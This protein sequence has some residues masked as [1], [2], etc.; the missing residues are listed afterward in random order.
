MKITKLFYLTVGFSV[1]AATSCE[2]KDLYDPEFQTKQDAEFIKN[3]FDFNLS[4]TVPINL[5]VGRKALVRVYGT[6]PDKDPAAEP[7]YTAYT[8]NNGEYSGMFV[9]PTSYINKTLYAVATDIHIPATVSTSGVSFV[10][11]AGR[12][13]EDETVKNADWCL[14]WSQYYRDHLVER[15]DNTGM[16]NQTDNIDLLTTGDDTKISV[17]FLYSGASVGSRVYYYYYSKDDVPATPTECQEIFYRF[18]N[19]GDR[20]CLFANEGQNNNG[21]LNGWANEVENGMIG[22]NQELL[23][24][25]P[26]GTAESGTDFPKDVYVG[27]FLFSNWDDVCPP[28]FTNRFFNAQSN[29]TTNAGG[30]RPYVES[31]ASDLVRGKAQAGVFKNAEAEVLFY[32][33]E[34]LPVTYTERTTP[35]DPCDHDFNDIILAVHTD[36]DKI[37]E[38]DIEELD[39]NKVIKLFEGTLLFEDL[40]PEQGDYDMNDVIVE[41]KYSKLVS[42]QD[43][44]KVLAYNYEFR[45]KYDG[46]TY[47]NDFYINV[48]GQVAPIKVYEN[49]AASVGKIFTGVLLENPGVF[50]LTQA[51]V[52]PYIY[53]RNTG[54]E[55]HLSGKSPTAGAKTEGLTAITKLYFSIRDDNEQDQY[56]FAMD[57]PMKNFIP[58]TESV[59]IDTEYP[60]YLKWVVSGGTTNKDWYN[61][62][63][64]SSGN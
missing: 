35:L 6:D 63:Q 40:F 20:F 9:L 48:P 42:N 43:G 28:I 23:Y 52:D 56:P 61:N 58:V 62:Y 46:A 13:S 16:I 10:T 14:K 34:D 51:S 12:A 31:T 57:I 29:I 11:S 36:F 3:A 53:V 59:K 50:T 5:S 37:D 44:E 55:V 38:G 26:D 45:P 25:G 24:Y 1:L 2:D 4:A 18:Y 22:K 54:Y 8:N 32:G 33:I 21:F 60:N 19:Q 17:S 30:Y 49:N 64:Q 41:Y 27:F 15:E 47:I 39:E 7:L